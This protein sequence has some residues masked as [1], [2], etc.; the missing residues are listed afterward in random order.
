MPRRKVRKYDSVAQVENKINEWIE[1]HK[2]E[3][4]NDMLNKAGYPDTDKLWDDEY[5]GRFGLDCGWVWLY[6]K[7]DEQFHEW[8]LDNNRYQDFVSRIRF[9]YSTQSTTLKEIQAKYILKNMGLENDYG[10][11]VRLD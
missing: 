3:I 2:D 6:A 8:F 11:Y 9:P 7:N 1:L 10:I 5:N 4:L